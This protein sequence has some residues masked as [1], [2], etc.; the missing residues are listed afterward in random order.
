M[1]FERLKLLIGV[2]NLEKIKKAKILVIGV[3]GVGSYLVEGLIRSAISDIT[4]VDFDTIDITNINRQLMTNLDNVGQK[5]VIEMKKRILSINKDVKVTIVDKYINEDNFDELFKEKYDFIC[6]CCDTL[7]VKKLL[8]KKC[9]KEN[10]NLIISCG[11]GNKLNPEKIKITTLDKTS[12][13]PI[14]KILRKFVKD[15]NIKKK[16]YCIASYEEIIK[17]NSKIIGSTSFVPSTAGL[18][19]ASY[20]IRKI[21]DF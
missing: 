2:E 17:T 1:Q 7:I 11:M 14:C 18:L 9:V 15:S 3:G 4:I 20:V 10:M 21:I 5:K 19:M 8:I 16:I 6:D 12:Y 13:D